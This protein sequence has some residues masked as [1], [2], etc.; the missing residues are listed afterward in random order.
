MRVAY[1]SHCPNL[2]DVTYAGVTADGN[3][4]ARITVSTPR[5]DDYPRHFHHF[6]YDVLKR[7]PLRTPA[8]SR[9]VAFYQIGADQ[10][11]EAVFDKMAHG[12]LAGMI[13]EWPIE[14]STQQY[15]RV[16]LRAP[17]P[18]AWFSMHST[19]PNAY[20]NRK[21]ASR[22]VIVRSWKARLGG[23]DIPTPYYSVYGAPP[24]AIV[25][26]SP[27]A[28]VHTLQP[29]DFVEA[30]VEYIVLPLSAGEYYGPN[31]NLTAALKSGADTW[32]MVLRE[33]VGNNLKVEARAGRV[34]HDYPI[35]VAVD[36]HQTADFTVT[37]GLGYV[38]V[39]FTGLKQPSG[40][41][42]W[43]TVDGKRDRVDQS[44]HGRDFW[45]TDYDPASK[46]YRQTYNVPLDSPGDQPRAVR[47]EFG[48]A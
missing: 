45:Q 38:P 21:W 48:P 34:L 39:T 26:L 33:A 30:E 28:D 47:F 46:T 22:G 27:P 14:K 13:E 16:G 20:E 23:R 41:E 25:E 24:S 37:G 5:V 42:L 35:V 29:G 36:E 40:F 4:A 9:R 2:S 43:Q 6:R 8:S 11:N 17:G 7:T 3:I 10:Y 15:A 12:N 1:E 32:K 18:V 31:A 19:Q 44:V